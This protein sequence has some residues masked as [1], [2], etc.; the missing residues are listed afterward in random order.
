MNTIY[1][2]NSVLYRNAFGSDPPLCLSDPYSCEV[3]IQM[4]YAC[5]GDFH[6]MRGYMSSYRM[7]GAGVFSR[8][9]VED[10]WVFHLR[11]Y[12]RFAL[13][14]GLANVEAFAGAMSRFIL[15]ALLAHR[16]GRGPSL[17]LRNRALFV[18]HLAVVHP[19][20]KVLEGTSRVQRELQRLGRSSSAT[21]ILLQCAR[22]IG[23]SGYRNLV[24]LTPGW[25]VQAVRRLEKRHPA[26]TRV[27]RRLVYGQQRQE[28]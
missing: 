21:A 23:R 19:L 10:H 26:L 28:T 9:S 1:H 7:H 5:C 27:R 16:R 20:W 6:Y 17:R 2:F 8:R 15:Y 22:H 24:G 14:L 25:M 4:V 12:R 3:T 18:A 13:Y 11:G